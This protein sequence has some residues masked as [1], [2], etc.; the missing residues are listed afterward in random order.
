MLL[1]AFILFSG[2][3]GWKY[4]IQSVDKANR[5]KYKTNPIWHLKNRCGLQGDFSNYW[6]SSG[7][8]VYEGDSKAP[9]PTEQSIGMEF[10]LADKATKV[11]SRLRKRAG[12]PDISVEEA[13]AQQGWNRT[14][15]SLYHFINW[16]GVDYGKGQPA[17]R[18][19]LYRTDP[20]PSDLAFGGDDFFV[21]DQRGYEHLV[22]CLASDFN[23]TP[24]DPRLR[25]GTTVTDIHWGND[26]VCITVITD[27][28][29]IETLCA[30]RAI[31]TFSIGVLQNTQ[32]YP[33]FHPALPENKIKAINSINMTH[34]L[35]IYVKLNR[36]FW[37]KKEYIGQTI[38]K[39][40]IM[41]PLESLDGKFSF[42]DNSGVLLL[43]VMDEEADSIVHQ[44]I[45]QTRHEI[46]QLLKMM[47][48]H[49]RNVEISDIIVPTW[50][51]DPLYRGT[52]STTPVGITSDTYRE[53]A[54]PLGRLHFSGEAT[55][56]K[57]HGYVHGAYIAGKNTAK[58]VIHDMAQ[59]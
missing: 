42:P 48:P 23:L 39:F 37:D 14:K 41:Q 46:T 11:T 38:G 56:E 5:Q 31:L 12:L 52:Y 49:E 10:Y 43:T 51:I 4:W 30:K 25:L 16:F 59:T 33:Y 1:I 6:H 29:S 32:G 55:S 22:H 13:M 34:F 58:Q 24:T 21:S 54:A 7:V 8:A 19:S 35:K 27:N 18:A 50:K 44:P 3:A 20:E 47:Y 17:K 26:C 2:R 36:T 45:D 15:S 28:M 57:F 53:L 9:I 40:M